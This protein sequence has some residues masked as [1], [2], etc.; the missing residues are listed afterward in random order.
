MAQEEAEHAAAAARRKVQVRQRWKAAAL[1][2]TQRVRVEELREK[3]AREARNAERKQEVAARLERELH[4]LLGHKPWAAVLSHFGASSYKKL[5]VQ[6]H[7]DRAPQGASFEDVVQREVVF[8]Y[9][10]QRHDQSGSGGGD[11][12][13]GG[14]ST[15]RSRPD[16]ERARQRREEEAHEW[17][18]RQAREATARAKAQKQ[19]AAEEAERR[20]NAVPDTAVL[21]VTGA[22]WAGFGTAPESGPLGYYIE[23][24]EDLN[25]RPVFRKIPPSTL[26]RADWAPWAQKA[27]QDALEAADQIW[28]SGF[29]RLGHRVEQRL[30]YMGACADERPPTHD[31]DVVDSRET[32]PCLSWL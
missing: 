28:F 31:W 16:D 17:R 21:R 1:K 32:E 15:P 9:V 14:S 12:G 11:G 20:R 2:E 23:L 25:G 5:L 24:E 22:A 18:E 19:A 7:P 30:T 3:Q 13:G 26:E 6:F 10:Q 8:K 29:W 4:A 27:A